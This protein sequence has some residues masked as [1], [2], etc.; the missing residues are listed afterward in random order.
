MT[1]LDHIKTARSLMNYANQLATLLYSKANKNGIDHR[2]DEF[3]DQLA[4]RWKPA[5]ER[6]W[7]YAHTHNISKH[8]L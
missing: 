4:Q 8:Q 3:Q 5:Y 1:R 6:A 7:A 2:S